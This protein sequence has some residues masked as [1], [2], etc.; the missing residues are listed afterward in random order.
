[1]D[2][3]WDNILSVG[4]HNPLIMRVGLRNKKFRLESG[5]HRIQLFHQHGIPL[6]P[7]TVQ[8]REECGPHLGDVM[9]DA[10][11]N[12]DAP[13]GFRISKITEEYMAPSEVFST[14]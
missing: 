9:T 4:L 13:Q 7:L 11:H 14:L 1:M 8:V 10:S 5:N 3:L 2:V 6:V 12:F